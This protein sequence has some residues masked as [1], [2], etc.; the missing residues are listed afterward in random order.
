MGTGLAQA[1]MVRYYSIVG[2]VAG[3]GSWKHDM[4]ANDQMMMLEPRRLIRLDL[5]FPT[6]GLVGPH[7]LDACTSTYIY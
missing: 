5:G 3:R 2:V 7:W 6:V 4:G 1:G